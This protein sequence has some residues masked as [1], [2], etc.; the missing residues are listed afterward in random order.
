[1]GSRR[2]R[3]NDDNLFRTIFSMNNLLQFIMAG[4]I[5]LA[6]WSFANPY[7]VPSLDRGP[8]CTRLP[9]PLG[10]NQ[11][12]LLQ[13][14]DNNQELS[15]DILVRDPKDPEI[16]AIGVQDDLQLTVVF[17]NDSSGPMYLYLPE[18]EPETALIRSVASV[19][20][21]NLI[22]LYL[23]ITAVQPP[24]AVGGVPN[25]ADENSSIQQKTQFNYERE[26]YV[27]RGERSCFVE[28]TID[29][30]RLNQAGV[31]AGEYRIRAHYRNGNHGT[32][33]AYF[34]SEATATPV[35]GM[36]DST[37]DNP[38]NLGHQGLWIGHSKSGEIRFR[39]EV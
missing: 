34:G 14:T 33:P 1:M 37:L 23:E 12:S 20:N 15:L 25:I 8:R 31:S 19:E 28:I 35:P 21:T 32:N 22:G 38:Q 9:H 36:A 5:L 27:L 29:N 4:V 17:R 39:I 18:G 30:T 26:V 2:R 16:N 24:T 11:R 10:G 13:Y 6:G 7:V 3:N